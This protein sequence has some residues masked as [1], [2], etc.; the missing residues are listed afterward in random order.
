LG[1]QEDE[2]QRS[3]WERLAVDLDQIQVEL[4]VSFVPPV[5]KDFLP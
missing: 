4:W 1:K 3:I 2:K 5:G